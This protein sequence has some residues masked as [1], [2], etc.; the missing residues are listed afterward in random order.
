MI[1]K[2]DFAALFVLQRVKTRKNIRFYIHKGGCPLPLKRKTFHL[3]W[4]LQV[5]PCSSSGILVCVCE[6]EEE[7][8]LV[9]QAGAR[10]YSDLMTCI[11]GLKRESWDFLQCVFCPLKD[12]TCIGFRILWKDT[13]W[14]RR[15]EN[16]RKGLRYVQSGTTA[17]YVLISLCQWNSI[18]QSLM[19]TYVWLLCF[20][21]RPWIE[22][23]SL[24]WLY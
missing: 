10:Y 22:R 12:P 14:E 5:T 3:C 21:G 24:E 17:D 6:R 8:A 4:Q 7:E 13:F 19:Y 2:S 20:F 11:A 16:W 23:L 9:T 1:D 15:I 18:F